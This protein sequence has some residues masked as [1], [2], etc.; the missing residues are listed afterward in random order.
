MRVRDR[1]PEAYV[2]VRAFGASSF[3]RQ[4]GEEMNL[5][6]VDIAEELRIQIKTWVGEIGKRAKPAKRT[7]KRP[8]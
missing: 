6:I 4:V 8:A 1:S 2:M 5:E 3:A 7:A